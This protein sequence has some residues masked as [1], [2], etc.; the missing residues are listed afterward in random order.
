MC[1]NDCANRVSCKVRLR[2]IQKRA[3]VFCEWDVGLEQVFREADVYCIIVVEMAH[4]D[5]SVNCACM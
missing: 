1:V 3:C 2:T 5:E 4:M